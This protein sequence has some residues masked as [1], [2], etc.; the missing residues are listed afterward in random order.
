MP[1]ARGDSWLGPA[2]ATTGLPPRAASQ[3]TLAAALARWARHEATLRPPPLRRGPRSRSSPSRPCW[4]APVLPSSGTTT[5]SARGAGGSDPAQRPPGPP[6][7]PRPAKRLHATAP[8]RASDDPLCG[9]PGPARALVASEAAPRMPLASRVEDRARA[10]LLATTTTMIMMTTRLVRQPSTTARG[11]KE[12]VARGI[13]PGGR[14]RLPW[15]QAH[16]LSFGR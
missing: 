6:P 8:T 11:S 9:S 3:P 2:G 4:L 7:A 16:G 13:E 5:Q 14:T 15:P 12:K 1:P 10:T